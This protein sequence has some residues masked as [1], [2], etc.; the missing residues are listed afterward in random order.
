MKEILGETLAEGYF[1][2]FVSEEDTR[3][4]NGFTEPAAPV[5]H[6][7]GEESRAANRRGREGGEQC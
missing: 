7:K 1:A 6:L 4:K 2:P 3:G 5:T